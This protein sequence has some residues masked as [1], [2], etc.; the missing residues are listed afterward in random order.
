MTSHH[1]GE[2]RT[3]TRMNTQ[4]VNAKHENTCSLLRAV[5]NADSGAIRRGVV[6]SPNG[7]LRVAMKSDRSAVSIKATAAGFKNG[8]GDGGGGQWR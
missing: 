6:E 1:T 3:P 2:A 8:G 7:G 5:S 4:Q